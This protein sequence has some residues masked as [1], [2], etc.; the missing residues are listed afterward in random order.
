MDNILEYTILLISL[1]LIEWIYIKLA[2]KYK[3]VNYRKFEN[4]SLTGYQQTIRGG[5]IIFIISILISVFLFSFHDYYF[6]AGLFLLTIISFLDDVINVNFRTRLIFHAVAAVLLLCQFKLLDLPI[7]YLCFIG[8]FIIAT[9]N[10]YNFMDGINGMTGGYSLLAILSFYYIN[11]NIVQFT[12][13]QLL[14]VTGLSL[15]VFNFFNFRGKAKCFAGDVGSVGIA[16]II[17]F[18][19]GQLILKTGDVSYLFLLLIYGID[20]LFTVFFRKIKGENIFEAHHSHLYQYL[21]RYLTLPHLYVS[22]IYVVSQLI[23]NIVLL[24][25][26]TKSNVYVF[27]LVL[28]VTCVYLTVRFYLEEKK[29]QYIKF[30][31]IKQHDDFFVK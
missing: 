9:I 2:E 14:V 24:A 10:A 3:F 23:I 18:F 15:I 19:M 28:V 1:F 30:N 16:F 7:A 29:K 17:L 31:L 21:V 12:S 8:V 13:A 27:I 25:L 6:L 11:S 26:L 4:R 20:T 5:G 22:S